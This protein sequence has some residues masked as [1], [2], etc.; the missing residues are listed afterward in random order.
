VE[1]VRSLIRRRIWIGK[2]W[3]MVEVDVI[4]LIHGIGKRPSKQTHETPSSSQRARASLLAAQLASLEGR[5]TRL[6]KATT[7]TQVLVRPI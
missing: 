5:R 2:C 6:T 4:K 7:P 1:V 3:D